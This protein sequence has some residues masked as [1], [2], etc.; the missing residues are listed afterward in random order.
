[1]LCKN[2]LPVPGKLAAKL[3]AVVSLWQGLKRAENGMPFS[4]DLGHSALSG[5]SGKSFLLGVFA[6]PER[7]RFE[8]LD[9][10]LQGAA[11]AGQFIDEIPQ[12]ANF[13]YLRAQASATVE[14]G[15]PTW[16]RLDVAS[17]RSF[18]RLLLPMWGNGQINMLLGAIDD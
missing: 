7:F 3:Q 16:L 12:D 4:D 10:G 5:L 18:S 9:A 13:S 17:G 6:A 11:A 15:E 2:P 1:M 8:F 14:A